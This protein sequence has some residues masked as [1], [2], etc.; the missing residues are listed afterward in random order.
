MPS[1][2]VGLL[3]FTLLS[4]P[5]LIYVLLNERGSRP[6]RVSSTFR[7]PVTVGVISVTANGVALLIFALLEGAFPAHTPDVDRLI[8]DPGPYWSS[9]YAYLLRWALGVFLLA[10]LLAAVTAGLHNQAAS[11]GRDQATATAKAV[12][13]LLS[14][15]SQFFHPEGG[16][17]FVSGWW[18]L[19]YLPEMRDKAK[20]VTCTLD[21][22]SRVQGWYFSFNPEAGEGPDRDILLS[23]PLTFREADG[24]TRFEERGAVCLTARHIVLMQVTYEDPVSGGEPG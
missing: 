9:D 13:R 6:V 7:E 24:S 20:R 8:R 11:A 14:R 23:A 4:T 18:K 1:T 12:P 21:D 3:L 5:G 19:V 22:G 16:V 17:D 15:I 10:C 2:F